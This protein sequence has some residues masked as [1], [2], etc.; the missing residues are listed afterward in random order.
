VIDSYYYLHEDGSLI[1]KPPGVVESDPDYF[2]SPF[3]RKVWTIDREDR[4]TVWDLV[5]EATALGADRTRV[6]DLV[7]TWNLTDEDAFEYARRRGLYLAEME[8]EGFGGAKF[9]AAKPHK[10]ATESEPAIVV[11]GI[12]RTALLALATLAKKTAIR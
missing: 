6:A 4:E 5:V 12:G 11:A 8:E 2:D 1:R 7:E 3:V 10:D 9:V